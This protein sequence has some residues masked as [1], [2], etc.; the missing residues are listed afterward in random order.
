MLAAER[1]APASGNGAPL[2]FEALGT[3]WFVDVDDG[4]PA[5]LERALTDELER[6]DRVWSRFRPDSLVASMARNGGTHGFAEPDL[7]LLRW[8]ARLYDA[9][10][11][12]VT[13]LIGQT[14]SDAGYDAALSLVPREHI[15]PTPAWDHRRQ[16]T[17]S[18]IA[19]DRPALIDVGA[20]GKG[21]AVDRVVSL[22]E[23][24]GARSYLVDAGGDIAVGESEHVIG[25]EHPVWP[26]RIIGTVTV[27][28][29]ADGRRSVCGSATNRRAWRDWHHIIDPRT[30][31][32]T[33]EVIAAWAIAGSAMH[34]DGLATALFFTAPERLQSLGPFD[35]V[36]VHADG[37]IRRS[38]GVTV[39]DERD[40]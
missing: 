3:R 23:Q 18:G 7:G 35:H 8:Y 27:G 9:T 5:R 38:P 6:I 29:T 17:G 28:G 32:P 20:A 33:S 26:D 24:T 10:D 16:L 34:A 11:G 37:S 21:F 30:G 14:L 36:V 12:A 4:I 39:F 25:L 31:A 15:T 13:P 2:E 22:I 19:L 1:G 40:R